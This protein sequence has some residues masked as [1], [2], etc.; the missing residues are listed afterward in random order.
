VVRKRVVDP[1]DPTRRFERR[2]FEFRVLD[3][4]GQLVAG[5]EFTTDSTGRGV[6]PAELRR[7]DTYTLEEVVSPVA[8]VQLQQT[9]FTVEKRVQQLRVVNQVTQPNTP[10]GV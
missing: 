6:C 7:D 8:N 1:S 10:Y 5:S 2:G 3:S 9:P 4:Q